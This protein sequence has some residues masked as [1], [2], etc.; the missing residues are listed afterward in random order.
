MSE[1]I[2]SFSTSPLKGELS[3]RCAHSKLVFISAKYMCKFAH[4]SCM[5]GLFEWVFRQLWGFARMGFSR[6]MG[7]FDSCGFVLLLFF[8]VFE[9]VDEWV[10]A[11]RWLCCCGPQIIVGYDY[12]H[13]LV[14]GLIRFWLLVES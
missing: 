3:T 4:L 2:S 11:S 1:R 7:L 9:M 14:Y 10:C 8:N 6:V 5:L 13:L 12:F